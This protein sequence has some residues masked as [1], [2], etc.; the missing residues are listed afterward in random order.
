MRHEATSYPAMTLESCGQA[1]S[2]VIV[3]RSD[4]P[5]RR[6]IVLPAIKI[7]RI[8]QELKMLVLSNV[9]LLHVILE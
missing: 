4:G 3:Q 9:V 7:T 6:Q 5:I 8:Y 2:T 1:E